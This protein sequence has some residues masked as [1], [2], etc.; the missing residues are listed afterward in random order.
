[1][2]SLPRAKLAPVAI[3]LPLQL[4]LNV[5]MFQV[6][7]GNGS[8][9]TESDGANPINVYGKTKREA[10][11]LVAVREKCLPDLAH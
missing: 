5:W 8:W 4:V 7:D 3:S 6:F 10:E 2:F 1:M 11:V 9:Y